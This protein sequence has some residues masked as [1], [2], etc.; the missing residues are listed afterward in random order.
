MNKPFERFLLS[1]LQRMPAVGFYARTRGWSFVIAWMHRISG[2]ILIFYVLIHI[3]TLSFLIT[4][5]VFDAKMKM[6]GFFLFIFLEWLLAAPVIFHALN[7][8]R[9]ILYEI[10]G[11][12]N[13]GTLLQWMFS[14]SVVYVL[15][16]ALMMIMGNQTVSP[17]LFWLVVFIFSACVLI[18]VAS[19][20][21]RIEGDLV[22]KL[23]RITGAFLLIMIPAHLMFMHLQPAIG[24]QANVVIARM[25][26]I[27]I[28]FVDLILVISVLLH[29]G[30][31]LISISKD[32]FKYRFVQNG[33][34]LLIVLI[35]VVFGWIGIKIII[36]SYS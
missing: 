10:F 33:L 4:P 24:H 21:W 32:Y 17:I 20:I 15:L 3:Y 34:S 29:A 5:E 36:I 31:G 19:R 9:L 6:F 16:Q 18:L 12:R 30:Y 27:F 2:I 22:W 28:K 25:Q 35:M 1:G 26:N 23:Q 11:T 8:G 13:E 7:G 14:L